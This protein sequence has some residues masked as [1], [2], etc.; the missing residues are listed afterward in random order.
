MF[1]CFPCFVLRLWARTEFH[2]Q[3]I[4][5]VFTFPELC[6]ATAEQLFGV[7]WSLKQKY[8]WKY[9]IC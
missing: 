9:K 6:M 4:D 5:I 3:V 1:F 8:V 2:I 7:G